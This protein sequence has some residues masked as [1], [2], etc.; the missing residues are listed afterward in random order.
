[1]QSHGDVIVHLGSPIDLYPAL[2]V[3]GGRPTL[4]SWKAGEGIEYLEGFSIDDRWQ[5]DQQ[6][7]WA[8]VWRCDKRSDGVIAL[9]G[10]GMQRSDHRSDVA[11]F[12][13]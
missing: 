12:A 11:R 3:V 5:V 6:A 8:P 1:V 10:Q 4:E 13:G 2:V 9:L 7:E